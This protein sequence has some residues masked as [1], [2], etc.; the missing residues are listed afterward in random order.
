LINDSF[1][2]PAEIEAEIKEIENEGASLG[3]VEFLHF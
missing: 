2:C 1:M 3:P